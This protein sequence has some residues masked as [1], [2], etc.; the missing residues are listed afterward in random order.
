MQGNFP[1]LTA[2]QTAPHGDWA[3]VLTT[4]GTDAMDGF[5]G[6]VAPIR[7]HPRYP[8]L[9]AS[10][11]SRFIF[12]GLG[13]LAAVLASLLLCRPALAAEQPASAENKLREAL[14]GMTIQL[15]DA[16][17]QLA[18]AQTEK[19][20][21]D[22]KS[23]KL[24]SD[25]KAVM[26]KADREKLDAQKSET[27]SRAAI[28]GKEDE[29]AKLKAEVESAK[30]D[31]EQREK[32]FTV[33]EERRKK[34]EEKAIVLDRRVAEQQVKNATM[35]QLGIEVLQRYE[36]FGLGDAISAREPFVGKTRVKFQNL[37]QDFQDKL[38]EQRIKP[39]PAAS[40]EASGQQKLKT[41]KAQETANRSD[42]KNS[43]AKPRPRD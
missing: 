4:D 36:K 24:E 22:E 11:S 1:K 32:L 20:E 21:L 34:F 42:K 18:T 19:A 12:R 26:Q 31:I 29:I 13:L 37:V 7:V 16:Q 30:V 17:T 9:P 33:S 38:A 8:W 2:L 15:R 35:Y 28:V 5:D 10:A 41:A 25:L 27:A 6:K 39:A 43:D 23:R 3:D 14:R 40:H